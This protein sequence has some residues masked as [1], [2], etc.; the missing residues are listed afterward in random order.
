M[1]IAPLVMCSL[2]ALSGSAL[3]A[4]RPVTVFLDRQGGPAENDD[5]AQ[6]RVPRFGG[7]DASWRGVVGC[8]RQRFGAFRVDVVD[9]R[10]RGGDFITVMIGGKASQFGLDDESVAGV[11]PYNGEVQRDAVVH[12]FSQVTGEDDVGELCGAAVHE[13]GHALGLEHEYKC[14]DAMSY[15][16][17]QCGPRQFLDVDAPCGED[18]AQ[19]C[20][21][22]KRSQNSYRYL[23]QAV[24]LRDTGA[25]IGPT[26]A[27]TS[28]P[29]A[30]D[31]ADDAANDGGD[32]ADPADAAPPAVDPW[33]NATPVDPRTAT[34]GPFG[35]GDA[36]A[37]DA[38]TDDQADDQVDAQA[39]DHADV[40]ADDGSCDH[41]SRA[42]L[43][44]PVGRSA[45][46]RATAAHRV[47]EH[48][49]HGWRHGAPRG[50]DGHAARGGH[51]HHGSRSGRY[52]W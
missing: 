40:Q 25:A 19:A 20:D 52:H 2:V 10:P 17:D 11:G 48:A 1:R 13:V 9:Q 8:V 35:R 22:G 7:A 34:R 43:I 39:D 15:F 47:V 32:D 23:A 30:D 28:A 27:G 45:P 14:G 38:D 49:H 16:L 5:G 37:D 44:A 31:A 29:A 24:G 6:V 50:R 18:S 21:S 3:A 46:P 4:P 12:V 51:H 41:G 36:Q 26:T 33:A 42:R